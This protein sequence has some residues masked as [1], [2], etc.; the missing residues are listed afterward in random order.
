MNLYLF[1]ENEIILFTLPDKKIGNFWMTD[2]DGMNIININAKDD[3]WFIS[4]S[5]NSKIIVGNNYV[6]DVILKLKSYYCIEKN[7]KRYYLF[8]D[9][10]LDNTFMSYMYNGNNELIIGKS[11]NSSVCVAID[12]INEVHCI[13]NYNNGYWNLKRDK[14]ALIYINNMIVKDEITLIR[15]GDVLNI[16]GFKIVFAFNMLFINNPFGNIIINNSILSLVNL[17]VNDEITLEELIDAP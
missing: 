14:N 6:D 10:V 5:N 4:S 3:E 16:Y 2:Q 17:N 9:N 7:S 11:S 8:V 15:N 13:L 12:I 1:D